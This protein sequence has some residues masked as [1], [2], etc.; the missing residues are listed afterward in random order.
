MTPPDLSGRVHSALLSSATW[1]P[2]S[3]TFSRSQLCSVLF[4][5]RPL[6]TSPPRVFCTLAPQEGR[7]SLT[8]DGCQKGP[9]GRGV[10]QRN[11]INFHPLNKPSL[12]S[13]RRASLSTLPT[14]EHRSTKMG[15]HKAECLYSILCLS[16]TS[17]HVSHHNST[18]CS[19][20]Y[21]FFSA[22]TVQCN[23][24]IENP[25]SLLQYA[26]DFDIF[27]ITKRTTFGIFLLIQN[28]IV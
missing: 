22:R 11:F 13:I 14:F 8:L 7:G 18:S 28:V 15:R 20:T 17:T 4:F 5:H 19:S 25:F 26:R 12:T 24:T 6:A 2:S 21:K 9:G 27:L 1:S 3:R 16:I 10:W 23:Q